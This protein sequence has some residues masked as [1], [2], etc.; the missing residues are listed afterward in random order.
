MNEEK[1]DLSP[2]EYIK[3]NLFVIGGGSIERVI[4]QD[5]AFAALS[6]LRSSHKEEIERMFDE[7]VTRLH[8]IRLGKRTG[9]ALI[10]YDNGILH[11]IDILTELKET[12]TK[13][14]P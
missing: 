8:G 5:D 1:K 14:K 3:Q 10:A 4:T 9:D 12:K 2:E 7:A 11:S 13:E 6:L